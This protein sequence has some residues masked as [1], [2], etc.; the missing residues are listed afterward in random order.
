MEIA[1]LKPPGQSGSFS[2]GTRQT[3][4]SLSDLPA[5]QAGHVDVITLGTAFVKVL[6]PLHVHQVKFV[7]QAMALEQFQSAINRHPVNSRV[8]PARLTQDLARVQMLLGGFDHSQDG[9]A[10]VGKTNPAGGQGRLQM[11]G[12]LGFRKWHNA[13]LQMTLGCKPV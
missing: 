7:H 11:S 5:A 9:T 8:Q 13:L 12:S 4:Q 1:T 6:L 2:V 10:L 3:E